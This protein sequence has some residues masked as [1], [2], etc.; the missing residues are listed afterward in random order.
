MPILNR[1]VHD[2]NRVFHPEVGATKD[3]ILKTLYEAD[4]D[5]DRAFAALGVYDRQFGA[6]QSRY[7]CS[8]PES[9]RQAALAAMKSALRRRASITF[10][11]FADAYA[12]L[13]LQ[14]IE[15]DPETKSPAALTMVLEGYCPW[16]LKAQ[17]SQIERERR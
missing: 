9:L 7:I 2:L 13:T 5:L 15:E 11:F 14:E 17:L 1:L 3:E 16:I 10:A 12:K 4:D 6:Q 8:I